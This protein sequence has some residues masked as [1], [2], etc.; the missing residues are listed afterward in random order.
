M[1][2]GSPRLF[3]GIESITTYS[4]FVFFLQALFY[5]KRRGFF[6]FFIPARA[7][8]KP[9]LLLMVLSTFFVWRHSSAHGAAFS[10]A[11]LA[12]LSF[13]DLILLKVSRETLTCVDQ[14]LLF[15]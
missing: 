12:V 14:T 6:A 9:Q 15:K 13:L 8:F 4:S 7:F 11:P 2:T 3:V 5:L 1:K 10:K